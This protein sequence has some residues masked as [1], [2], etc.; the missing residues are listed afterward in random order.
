[1][2]DQDGDDHTD[3]GHTGAHQQHDFPCFHCVY[4]YALFFSP[5]W[6]FQVFCVL[7]K[8]AKKMQVFFTDVRNNLHLHQKDRSSS[9][10]KKQQHAY[11]KA[12]EKKCQHGEAPPPKVR[13]PDNER[14]TDKLIIDDRGT[15]CADSE[16][17]IGLY[18]GFSCRPM[19]SNH[20][21]YMQSP[22]FSVDTD[23]ITRHASAGNA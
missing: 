5:W 8:T 6:S 14:T 15:G 10:V 1:M 23:A 12:A 11:G 4:I 3:T 13:H 18:N 16:T 20:H 22:W 21:R 2:M 19:V 7:T 17:R 9:V